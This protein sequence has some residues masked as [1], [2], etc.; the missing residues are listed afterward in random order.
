MTSIVALDAIPYHKPLDPDTQYTEPYLLRDLNKAYCGFLCTQDRGDI[1]TELIAL[2]VRSDSATLALSENY[3]PGGRGS[4]GDHFLS[5]GASK[6]PESQLGTG[7]TSLDS[8]LPI[9]ELSEPPKDPS[10]SRPS[11]SILS[12]PTLSSILSPAPSAATK[13]S[14]VFRLVDFVS[15]VVRS[16]VKMVTSGG[17]Q[18]SETKGEGGGG[19]GGEGGEGGGG[20]V[21]AFAS[22]L[23]DSLL[24]NFTSQSRTAQTS[25]KMEKKEEEEEGEREE[26]KEEDESMGPP[27]AYRPDVLAQSIITDALTQISATKLT[28]TPTRMKK[29]KNQPTHPP[30]WQLHAYADKMADNVIMESIF[31]SDHPSIVVNSL[32]GSS[33]QSSEVTGQAITTHE[34]ADNLAEGVLKDAM[35]AGG[36]GGGGEPGVSQEGG[37]GARGEAEEGEGG[38]GVRGEAEEGEGGKGSTPPLEVPGERPVVHSLDRRLMDTARER[39]ERELRW[40]SPKQSQSF[41]HIPE[42]PIRSIRQEML[43]QIVAYGQHKCTSFSS[44]SADHK[45]T[46]PSSS[47][48]YLTAPSSRTSYAWSVCSTRDEESRPVSPTDMD[49][50]ALSFVPTV[51]EF[52]SLLAEMII[53]DAIVTVIGNNQVRDI[54][55]AV[56]QPLCTWYK[57]KP[58]VG[59]QSKM[60]LLLFT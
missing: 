26:E 27:I 32:G 57:F 38:G 56:A 11:S 52:C 24:S 16:G 50:I 14:E 3:S 41:T 2:R 30:E 20:G 45:D 40:G 31:G 35:S 18:S 53:R 34:Y 58:E 33:K 4:C 15:D 5:F 13:S 39:R 7:G 59:M 28:A 22:A 25:P 44:E 12:P 23:S 60:P 9:V 42:S 48:F 17:D 43:R 47:S 54:K 46:E 49:Q 55:G 37:G 29:P 36:G 1:S 51:D 10:I 6:F 19:E 21:K 8:L